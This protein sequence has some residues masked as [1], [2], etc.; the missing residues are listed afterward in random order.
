MKPLHIKT[1][2]IDSLPLS[3]RIGGTVHL[4][5]ESFQPSGSFKNRGIGRMVSW[6]A[7][8]GAKCFISS[9]GGNAG[10]AVA[11]SGGQ[12]GLPVMV[13]VPDGSSPFM[14]QKIELEGAEVMVHGET[15]DDAAEL[16]RELA[17]VPDTIYIPPYD[18]P[19][20]WEGNASLIDEI[21]EQGVRPDGILLAVGGGGL[22]CG[23]VEGLHRRGM[24][25]VPII[26]VE[27]EGA[28]AFHQ[29][30]EADTVVH[31][32]HVDTLATSIAGKQV[33]EQALI[34]ARQ[35]EVHSRLVSD[36]AAVEATCLFAND[37]RTIVE[38]AC[39][40]PLALIYREDP[41]LEQ[42]KN[43]V[44]IA[45]GGS[46]VNLELLDMWKNKVGL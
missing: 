18:D 11:Y 41:L 28:A 26:A 19:L 44:V 32:D 42:F 5:L 24:H 3:E 30:L 2:L 14:M 45:C 39:G 21:V 40:A 7:G 10:L 38:P 20:I 37:H 46:A 34:W 4:K 17:E 43:L 33:T 36:R 8:N 16:A 35:H 23:V 12:L 25:D 27:T 6:H 13:V 29:S 15:F 22:F 1:P 31:L 9:S